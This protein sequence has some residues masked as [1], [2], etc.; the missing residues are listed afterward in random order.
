MLCEQALQRLDTAKK[1]DPPQS[2]VSE[3][4][5]GSQVLAAIDQ[6]APLLVD[7]GTIAGGLNPWHDDDAESCVSDFTGSPC[8][9]E[10]ELEYDDSGD[11][12]EQA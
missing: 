7:D 3:S 1:G 5:Q 12:E 2:V 8:R 4:D 9:S 10:W 6:E 11:L